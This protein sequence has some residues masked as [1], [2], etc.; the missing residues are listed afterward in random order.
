MLK[1]TQNHIRTYKNKYNFET[2]KKYRLKATVYDMKEPLA[3]KVC[4]LN[5]W[6]AK[7]ENSPAKH[8]EYFN[9]M[10]FFP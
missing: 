4:T 6:E 7:G 1:I 9:S 10:V 3:K 2:E 5:V 8:G